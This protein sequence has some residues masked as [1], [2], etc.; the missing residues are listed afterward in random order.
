MTT[1]IY[2]LT[3]NIGLQVLQLFAEKMA[4]RSLIGDMGQLYYSILSLENSAIQI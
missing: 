3:E 1:A 2:K 4:L